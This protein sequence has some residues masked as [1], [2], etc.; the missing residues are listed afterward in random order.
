MNARTQFDC[1]Q[2]TLRIVTHFFIYVFTYR[3]LEMLDD[4]SR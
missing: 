2:N 4:G 1:R 3:P